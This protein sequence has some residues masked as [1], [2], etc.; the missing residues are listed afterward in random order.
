MA[1]RPDPGAEANEVALEA[2]RLWLMAKGLGAEIDDLRLQP[3]DRLV[4]APGLNHLVDSADSLAARCHELS[5]VVVILQ[6]EEGPDASLGALSSLVS[7]LEEMQNG[8]RRL[9]QLGM[10]VS[11]LTLGGDRME[12]L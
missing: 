2:Q 5:D 10:G 3:E 12:R 8:L 7:A 11:S 6:R 1:I 9:A 4:P